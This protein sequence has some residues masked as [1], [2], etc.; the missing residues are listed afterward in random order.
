MPSSPENEN[1]DA[2]TPVAKALVEKEIPKTGMEQSWPATVVV[3][4]NNW[5]QGAPPVSYTHLTLPTILIV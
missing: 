3:A 5:S 1:L 2:P 4:P